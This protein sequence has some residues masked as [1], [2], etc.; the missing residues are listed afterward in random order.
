MK[1]IDP[2][3][4]EELESRYPDLAPIPEPD[5]EAF[6][7][8]LEQIEKISPSDAI[9]L[10][11]SVFDP[12]VLAG[13][14]EAS[15]ARRSLGSARD[16][17]LMDRDEDGRHTSRGKVGNIVAIG[18]VMLVVGAGAYLL[19]PKPSPVAEQS[20]SV[21]A[22]PTAGLGEAYDPSS[23]DDS[24]EVGI[25]APPTEAPVA[26]ETKPTET[27]TPPTETPPVVSEPGAP[28]Q[29]V[30]QPT[31]VVSAPT[32]VPVPVSAATP[33]VSVV[34]APQVSPVVAPPAVTVR[35]I[36]TTPVAPVVATPTAVAAPRQAT[37]VVPAPAAVPNVAAPAKAVEPPEPAA[38]VVYRSAPGARPPT[39]MTGSSG[40]SSGA[41]SSGGASSAAPASGVMFRQGQGSG[42][43]MYRAPGT[44]RPTPPVDSTVGASATGAGTGGTA[45]APTTAPAASAPTTAPTTAPATSVPAPATAAPTAP[46]SGAPAPDSGA[47]SLD[48]VLR[49]LYPEGRVGGVVM[50]QAQQPQLV[51]GIVQTAASSGGDADQTSESLTKGGVI[52]YRRVLPPA[53]APVPAPAPEPAPAP[54]PA[55]VPAGPSYRP[56]TLLEGR[57]VLRTVIPQGG[58]APV[59][60]YAQDGTTWLG[61]AGLS[62]GRIEVLFDLVIGRDGAQSKV[63]G[64]LVGPDLAL[65]LKPKVYDTNPTLL[66]DM[67]RAGIGGVADF[68]ERATTIPTTTVTTPGGG[69]V[70]VGGKAKGATLGTTV[71][72]AM[73]DAIRLPPATANFIR[74]A[75]VAPGTPVRILIFPSGS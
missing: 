3:V 62:N 42:G 46:A 65:G 53:P 71:A 22:A 50:A 66:T 9:Y 40:A 68:V 27:L 39:G 35:P 57:L 2:V 32:V 54:A 26:E 10:Q 8:T 37:V 30:P 29:T 21:E 75:E 67:M 70:T 19:W 12:E 20:E 31:P 69:T 73:A 72:G 59:L 36:A 28:M 16:R 15:G 48:D 24:A 18:V 6:E 7:V 74:V 14:A 45:A 47:P 33:R 17:V 5:T 44:A 49:E 63:Q 60:V 58:S 11:S 1:R 34:T 13:G 23:V 64:R 56:G 55:P 52:I 41:A 25:E 61:T 38:P 43:V 51:M 4:R